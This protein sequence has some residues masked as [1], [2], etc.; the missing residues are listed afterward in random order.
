[1]L[2]NAVA[3]GGFMM[4]TA[5]TD[6]T[7]SG[8]TCNMW[9]LGDSADAPVVGSTSWMTGT[10]AVSG[11]VGTCTLGLTTSL[12]AGT[13]YGVQVAASATKAGSFAPIGLQTTLNSGLAA[14]GTA[15]VKGPVVDTNM[16]FDSAFTVAAPPTTM[17]LTATPDSASTTKTNPGGSYT[18]SFSM[19][20]SFAEGEFVA[21]PYEIELLLGSNGARA[22]PLATASGANTWEKH[23]VTYD[24]WTWGTTCTNT[25]F[26]ATPADP[27]TEETPKMTTLTPA[28]AVDAV[29][30]ALII[31]VDQDLTSA[32]WS[33]FLMKFD[34]AVTN[35]LNKLGAT[36]INY[37]LLEQHT[38]NVITTGAQKTAQFEVTK[39][40]A[41]G[42]NTNLVSFGLDPHLAANTDQ[43][44]GAY[45]NTYC[46][47]AYYYGNTVSTAGDNAFISS[48][49][50]N[51]QGGGSGT[52]VVLIENNCGSLAAGTGVELNVP[53]AVEMTFEIPVAVPSD[54]TEIAVDCSAT[55]TAGT[56]ANLADAATWNGVAYGSAA[57]AA[58]QFAWNDPLKIYQQSVMTKFTP[59]QENAGNCW[60]F[61]RDAAATSTNVHRFLCKDVGALATG[62]SLTL[63][64]QYVVTNLGKDML[65]G[66]LAPMVDSMTCVMNVNVQDSTSLAATASAKVW[67][68][69]TNTIQVDGGASSKY[70]KYAGFFVTAQAYKYEGT[71]AAADLINYPV[72]SLGQAMASQ[73]DNFNAGQAT[74]DKNS[75]RVTLQLSASDFVAP[76]AAY[77]GSGSMAAAINTPSVTGQIANYAALRTLPFVPNKD[78]TSDAKTLTVQLYGHTAVGTVASSTSRVN[79]TL[80]LGGAAAS[81]AAT[82][83][84]FNMGAAYTTSGSPLVADAA[85]RFFPTDWAALL[86]TG[87]LGTGVLSFTMAKDKWGQTCENANNNVN[88]LWCNEGTLVS[89][90]QYYTSTA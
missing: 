57:N 78:H 42:T 89:G 21:A 59:A 7:I 69:S 18:V 20:F 81:R 77:K 75:V 33:T 48:C 56:A 70:R 3:A 76:D 28:C 22:A 4:I 27:T 66:Y 85:L 61:G 82:T 87:S 49:T 11:Q 63:A 45:S 36:T 31:S 86:P 50:T 6:L 16:V 35:P 24:G 79:P 88:C 1:M 15:G 72:P 60:Y 2:D 37:A 38:G 52:N 5:P 46:N 47:V 23:P 55:V 39:E 40:T 41:T 26:G 51:A 54:R 80:A 17:S 32:D 19:A 14:S 9:A 29:T 13:A 74:A 73:S 84:T 30:G 8:L 65:D 62:T 43:G 64:F 83:G 10:L 58:G 71:V 67:Y 53:T 12:A 68:T 44:V 34:I 90:D 25:Q